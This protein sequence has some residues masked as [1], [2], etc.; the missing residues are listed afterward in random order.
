MFHNLIISYFNGLCP[1][2]FPLVFLEGGGGYPALNILTID[3]NLIRHS[4]FDRFTLGEALSLVSG[5]SLCYLEGTN[6]RFPTALYAF[7]VILSK[8]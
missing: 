2:V 1:Q 3:R 5:L 7:F 8:I 4:L 6:E